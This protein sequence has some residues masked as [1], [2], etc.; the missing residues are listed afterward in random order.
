MASYDKKVTGFCPQGGTFYVC[1]GNVTQFLG[2]CTRDP[3]ASG[4]GICPQDSLRYTSY[5]ADEYADVPPEACASSRGDWYTCAYI[6]TAFMGCC[7]ENPCQ[8]DGCSQGNLTSA[9]LSDN[10]TR[11]APFMT[12]TAGAATASSSSSTRLSTGTIV[13][14]AIGA[15]LGAL[16]FGALLFFFFKRHEKQRARRRDEFHQTTPDRSPEMNMPNYYQGKFSYLRKMTTPEEIERCSK[17]T[18]KDC[19]TPTALSVLSSSPEL[20][21][22]GMDQIRRP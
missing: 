17:L 9:R 1:Q 19:Q 8:N 18:S 3:C 14:I 16:I 5:N 6:T 2:C 12:S 20:G 13:G 11:A 15:S 21:M 22:S 10:T 4:S 7:L